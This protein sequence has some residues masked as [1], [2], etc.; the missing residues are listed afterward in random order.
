LY[1]ASRRDAAAALPD[2][3]DREEV[4]ARVSDIEAR[5]AAQLDAPTT[6]L[7]EALDRYVAAIA[8]W[9][10]ELSPLV[11]ALPR[12]R[13]AHRPS[14]VETTL[15]AAARGELTEAEVL[16]RVGVMAPAWDVAVPTYAERPALVRDAI[17]RASHD[18]SRGAP[19][20]HDAADA[21]AAADAREVPAP[22]DALHELA[23]DLA[24]RDDVWFAKAQWMVRRALLARADELGVARE[25]VGWLRFEVLEQGIAPEEAR[26]QAAGA[27]A[28][29]ERASRWDMPLVVPE[30][31]EARA[32]HALHG[33]GTG[34]RVTG[35][36]V[37]FA[38]LGAAIAVRRGDIVV[39]RAV[40]PAL[41]VLVIGCAALVSETGGLL[42]HGAALARELGVPCVV[43]CRDAWSRLADGML[44]TVDGDRGR[45][46]LVGED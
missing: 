37:R 29:A 27:R 4:I 22:R 35:R 43:G 16:A 10:N 5:L 17:A 18:E 24:E 3:R 8:I 26:R 33:V 39:A 19:D 34:P 45:V 12:V 32:G 21:H 36:V 31:A 2:V 25:D 41:A 15:A 6:T 11:R 40:T 20:S 1:T 42:D 7:R 30:P 46:E 23:A 13:G 9:A 14:A 38:S 28:A 44:V